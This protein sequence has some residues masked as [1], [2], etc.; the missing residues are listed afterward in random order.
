MRIVEKCIVKRLVWSSEGLIRAQ[1]FGEW[2]ED[3]VLLYRL[4][5]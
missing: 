5:C 4:V 3:V 2:R 1:G